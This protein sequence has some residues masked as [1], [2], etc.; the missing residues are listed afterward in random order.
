LTRALKR[1]QR[2]LGRK[3]RALRHDAGLSQEAAAELIGLSDR[4]LRL[5]ELG[6]G[7]ATLS[8]LVAISQAYRVDVC[9]LLCDEDAETASASAAE[10]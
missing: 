9:E 7:N 2:K 5:L 8:T 10:G 3:L 4:G 6:R 1:V